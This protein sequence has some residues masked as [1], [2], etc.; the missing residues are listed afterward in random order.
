MKTD[1]AIGITR[2]RLGELAS[3]SEQ[4][5]RAERQILERAQAM[6]SECDADIK[7]L[8]GP[9]QAGDEEAAKQYQTKV[10]DRGRLETVIAQARNALR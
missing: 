1:Q 3:M 5:Q 10:T 4:T 6:L 9:A 7:R 2:N 8:S